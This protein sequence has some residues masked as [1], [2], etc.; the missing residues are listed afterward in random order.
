MEIFSCSV[1][2]ACGFSTDA[3]ADSGMA[4]VEDAVLVLEDFFG[5]LVEELA[6]VED[7]E[8]EDDELPL[9]AAALLTAAFNFCM[10]A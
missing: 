6:A 4:A 5:A 2:G 1:A 9:R 8:E 10:V 3:A 7:D